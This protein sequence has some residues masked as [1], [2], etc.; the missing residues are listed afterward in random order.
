MVDVPV[1]VA[2]GGIGGLSAAIA[3]AKTGLPVRVIERADAF[4]AIGYGIQLAPNAFHAFQKLGIDNSILKKCSLPEEGLL[5]DAE[6]GQIL[7]RLPMGSE[8]RDRFGQPYAVIHRADLHE[9]L[10]AACAAAG[11]ELLTGCELQSFSDTGQQVAL[12]TTR[13]KLDAQALIAA[14]GIWSNT[15]STLFGTDLPE[16][17]GYVAFRRVCPMSEVPAHLGKNAV[18]LWAGPGYHMIHYP[19]RAGSLFNLVAVFDYRI[20][21]E[22]EAD[23]PF[24]DRLVKRFSGACDEVRALLSYIDLTRHWEIASINPIRTWA[25]GRVTLVGDSAHAM[26]QAMAQGA[27]QAIEDSIV[28]ARCV[29]DSRRNFVAAFNEFNSQRLLRATRVQYMSRYVWELIHARD[30]YADLRLDMLRQFR[31]RDVLETL[32]WLYGHG[33]HDLTEALPSTSLRA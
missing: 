5:R 32:G 26:V 11:A 33:Q 28:L 22:A 14:D 19:L 18:I 8:M 23:M 10:V 25:K 16:K 21:E 3:L 7:L 9:I 17:L 30:A 13:G 4:Q 2:G 29:S 1:T 20:Q 15:R 31:D 24:A 12:E 27:C 6:T